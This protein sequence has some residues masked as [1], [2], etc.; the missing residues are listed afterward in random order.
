VRALQP[1]RAGIGVPAAAASGMIAA[2]SLAPVFDHL[3]VLSELSL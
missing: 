1:P 2:N 3:K